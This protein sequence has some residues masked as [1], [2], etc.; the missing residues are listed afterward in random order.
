MRNCNSFP[1][2]LAPVQHLRDWNHTH[3]DMRPSGV[4]V[5]VLIKVCSGVPTGPNY[6]QA[7]R[8]FHFACGAALEK[9]FSITH[10]LEQVVGAGAYLDQ[11]K[12]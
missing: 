11:E 3:V 8:P 1:N 6:L 4:F 12:K 9:C 10:L 5:G 2:R 7:H